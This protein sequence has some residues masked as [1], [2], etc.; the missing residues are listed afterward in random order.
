[1]KWVVLCLQ[2]FKCQ[3]SNQQPKLVHCFKCQTHGHIAAKCDNAQRCRSCAGHHHIKDCNQN[4]PCGAN[5]NEKHN[6]AY[7]C[8]HKYKEAKQQARAASYAEALKNKSV[9]KERAQKASDAQTEIMKNLEESK[10]D[11]ITKIA[12]ERLRNYF[13]CQIDQLNANLQN[14]KK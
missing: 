2:K 1:M 3:P 11:Q 7:K 5:C 9:N 8:C 13:Q 4:G 12:N 14:I 10:I 6:A